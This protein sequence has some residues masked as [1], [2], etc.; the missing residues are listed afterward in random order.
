VT[1]RQH[2]AYA[3]C[4]LEVGEAFN[5]APKGPTAQP[6]ALHAQR[7]AVVGAASR[8]FAKRLGSLWLVG[9]NAGARIP[10]VGAAGMWHEALNPS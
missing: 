6:R 4:P 2:K 8:S 7:S 9:S 3:Q 5:S 1:T 10:R